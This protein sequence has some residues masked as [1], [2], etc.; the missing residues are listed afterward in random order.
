ML[1]KSRLRS[2]HDLACEQKAYIMSI[3][4][5]TLDNHWALT[6]RPGS[7]NSKEARRTVLYGVL[8][9]QLRERRAEILYGARVSG[10]ALCIGEWP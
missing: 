5:C 6:V 2:I 10:L 9:S 7:C 1:P 3:C 4:Q 8:P